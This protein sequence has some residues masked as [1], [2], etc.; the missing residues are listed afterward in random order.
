[1]KSVKKMMEEQNLFFHHHFVDILH[2][3]LHL[4]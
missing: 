2:V 1:M 3:N 4:G